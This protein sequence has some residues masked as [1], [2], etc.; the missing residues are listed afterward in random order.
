[1]KGTVSF[2]TKHSNVHTFNGGSG[3]WK[4]KNTNHTDSENIGSILLPGCSVPL[5][6][7]IKTENAD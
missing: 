6:Q 5:L 7:E 3:M 2:I 1:M 4:K